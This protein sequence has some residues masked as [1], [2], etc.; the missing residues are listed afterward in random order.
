MNTISSTE[1]KPNNQITT[2]AS[3][4]H[5]AAL[6]MVIIPFGNIIGPLLVWVIKKEESPFI[7]S[8]GKESLNFQISLSIYVLSLF[9]L[10]CVAVLVSTV[11]V[12][13]FPPMIMGG[14]LAM[15]AIMLAWLGLMIVEVVFIVLASIEASKGNAYEYP[16][17][18][19]FIK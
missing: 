5:L 11:G 9:L 8:H 6:A 7:D 4:C 14:F 15:P 16:F 12:A 19:R 17:T 3:A 2:W 18:I 13:V 1:K 10:G